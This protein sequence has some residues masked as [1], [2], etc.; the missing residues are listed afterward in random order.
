MKAYKKIAVLGAGS[1][2]VALSKMAAAK[3]QEVVLW[4][5]N[6]QVCEA[7]NL[8]HHHPHSLSQI[9]LP[10]TIRASLDLEE[11]LYGASVVFLTLPLEAMTEVLLRAKAF[12]SSDVLLVSTAKGITQAQLFLPNDIIEH[13][14]AKELH[15][16][17]LYLSGPS[18]AIELA[19]GL[20]T[21]MT[22]AS[23]L[24]PDAQQF[25]KNFSTPNC[26]LYY[27]SDVIGVLVGGALKNVIAIAA[28]VCSELKLGKNAQASLITRGLAEMGRLA[29]KMGGHVQTLMGLSG[30]GDLVLSATDAMSRN[31][32][33]GT[34]LA[35]GYNREESLKQIGAVVEGANTARA[36]VPLMEHYGVELP[37]SHAVYRVLYQGLPPLEGIESLLMRKL[38]DENTP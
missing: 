26:R 10:K 30:V 36:I 15:Q 9:A 12:L 22:I 24:R 17:T 27:T 8:D 7:I 2:G 29:K 34:L 35:Q 19:Q 1:F 31:F 32:R 14:V 28:G 33:L 3:A 13:S 6:A 11:S 21:A 38:K 4:G 5:R 16:R 37:I 18:F 23:V 25:R 20:P